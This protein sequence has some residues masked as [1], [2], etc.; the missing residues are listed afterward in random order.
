MNNL[1]NEVITYDNVQ[2]LGEM[3]AIK[4][5]M[6]TAS[7][8]GGKLVLYKGLLYDVY[9]RNTVVNHVFSDGL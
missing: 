6:T 3:I 2:E 4:A 7:H 9:K 5:L 8:S 1:F